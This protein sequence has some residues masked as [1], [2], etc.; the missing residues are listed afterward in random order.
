MEPASCTEGVRNEYQYMRITFISHASILIETRGITILSDPWWRGP[1]FGAQWWNYP[2]PAIGALDGKRIDYIYVSHGHHDHLHPGTLKTL[3]RSAIVLVS[4]TGDLAPSI[5][6]LG[7]DV[8]EIGP[9]EN[10]RLADQLHARILP[11]H[12]GDTLLAI[13]DGEEVCL[14]LNDALHSAPHAVQNHFLQKLNALYPTIHYVFCGYGAASHF[15][16]CYRI[17][18]KNS[19][20]SA[21]ARQRYF[22]SQWA[23]IVALLSPRYAFPF[24]ADVVFL[25]TDLQWVNEPTHNTQRPIEALRREYPDFGGSA[26]DIAPGFQIAENAIAKDVRRTPISQARLEADMAQQIQRANRYGQVEWSEVKE[27]RDL[28]ATNIDMCSEY[29]SSF[30]S[31]YSCMILFRNCTYGLGIKKKRNIIEVHAKEDAAS[32][33]GQA[34][35]TLTTRLPYLRWSLTTQYGDEIL[36]VGSGGIFEYQSRAD[37]ARSIHREFATMIRR[38]DQTPT[39]SPTG[40]FHHAKQMLKSAIG[41]ATVDPYDLEKWTVYTNEST[42]A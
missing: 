23:R 20:A 32:E 15:P 4:A 6:E 30:E 36:F 41:V 31:D 35:L 28:L 19:T 39:R 33:A 38:H 3:P 16:N 2:A 12:H 27:V 25:E 22:N 1:C 5:R 21:A 40:L 9:D 14:N 24:A 13:D 18:G 8:R 11:T 26:I 17:P 7:F 37:V 10:A 42:N 29:L 34:N